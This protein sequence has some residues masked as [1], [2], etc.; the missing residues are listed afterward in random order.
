MGP[1]ERTISESRLERDFLGIG[2][3]KPTGYGDPGAGIDAERGG[4][5]DIGRWSIVSPARKEDW[6]RSCNSD[7]NTREL[8]EQVHVSQPRGEIVSK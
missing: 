7:N 1:S 6:V 8:F 2:V 3:K 5:S 4:K